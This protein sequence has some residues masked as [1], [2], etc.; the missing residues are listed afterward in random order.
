MHAV[1]KCCVI[2]HNMICEERVVQGDASAYSWDLTD[3]EYFSDECEGE[4]PLLLSTWRSV[5]IRNMSDRVRDRA[6]YIEL[7]KQ[8]VLHVQSM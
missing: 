4:D 1:I 7:R 5:F 8:L 3:D 2:L 6:D